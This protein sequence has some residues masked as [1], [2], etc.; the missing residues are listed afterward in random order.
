MASET[1]QTRQTMKMAAEGGQNGGV[2]DDERRS[3]ATSVC[4]SVQLDPNVDYIECPPNF[5]LGKK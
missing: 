3:L 4:P 2:D 1:K 5:P